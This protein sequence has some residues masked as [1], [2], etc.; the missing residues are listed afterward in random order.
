MTM[1]TP[2]TPKLNAQPAPD[3]QITVGQNN[4]NVIM[5]L[6]RGVERY[7]VVL[8]FKSA[9]GLSKRLNACSKQAKRWHYGR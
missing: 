4:G 2:A 1:A 8:A 3:V 5:R 7:D 9:L 6:E